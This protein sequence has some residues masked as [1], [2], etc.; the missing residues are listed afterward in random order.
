ME[1]RDEADSKW[2][3]EAT[4]MHHFSEKMRFDKSHYSNAQ[5][6]TGAAAMPGD[7]GSGREGGAG[8]QGFTRLEGLA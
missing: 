6:A 8:A 7:T 4:Q 1:V 3:D 5:K 2:N